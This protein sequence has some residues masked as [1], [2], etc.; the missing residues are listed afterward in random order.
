MAV[1]WDSWHGA[2]HMPISQ[3]QASGHMQD[4]CESRYLL[5]KEKAGAQLKAAGTSWKTLGK[6]SQIIGWLYIL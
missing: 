3:C 4:R 2:I 6:K 5:S 1:A